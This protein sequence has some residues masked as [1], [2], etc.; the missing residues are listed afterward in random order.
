MMPIKY[1]NRKERPDMEQILFQLLNLLIPVI[2]T[3]ENLNQQL[4][5][6]DSFLPD[7]NSDI[8]LA[9]WFVQT[10]TLNIILNKHSTVR[11]RIIRNSINRYR[12]GHMG[13]H[14]DQGSWSDISHQSEFLHDTH[15]GQCEHREKFL[16]KLWF[17]HFWNRAFQ[18][19]RIGCIK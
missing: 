15:T 4:V 16:H 2:K 13:E 12:Y 9:I 3:S 5:F 6:Q 18:K 17:Q 19:C 7:W 14:I 8:G 10:V 1:R 11:S